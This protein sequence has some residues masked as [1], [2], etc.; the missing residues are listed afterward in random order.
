M[1]SLGSVIVTGTTCSRA[2]SKRAMRSEYTVVTG[3]RLGY[4]RRQDRALNRK[5]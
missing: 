3:V 1:V 2:V 5:T 4:K